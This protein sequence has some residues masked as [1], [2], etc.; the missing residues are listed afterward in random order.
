[1]MSA[2]RDNLCIEIKCRKSLRDFL[3]QKAH[4]Y[5]KSTCGVYIRFL[6]RHVHIGDL[7][8]QTPKINKLYNAKN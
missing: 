1:M 8:Q 6:A 4:K 7:G 5:S 3:G 2:G